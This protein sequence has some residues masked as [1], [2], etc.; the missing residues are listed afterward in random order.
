MI[1]KFY[2]VF[3]SLDGKKKKEEILKVNK[4]NQADNELSSSQWL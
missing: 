3:L 2:L 1:I 4:I